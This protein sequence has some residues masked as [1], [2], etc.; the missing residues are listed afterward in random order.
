M[1]R[2]YQGQTNAQDVRNINGV[3]KGFR[4]P[5]AAL[6]LQHKAIAATAFRQRILSLIEQ[7][8]H[9]SLVDGLNHFMDIAIEHEN[10]MEELCQGAKMPLL[11]CQDF[12]DVL[13]RIM[14][15][16]PKNVRIQTYGINM[17]EQK[18]GELG[19][20]H[21]N[22]IPTICL[23]IQ[24][25]GTT[26]A[27]ASV[28]VLCLNRITSKFLTA[29]LSVHNIAE[30]S[31]SLSHSVLIAM[32]SSICMQVMSCVVICL[33][34]YNNVQDLDPKA[35]LERKLICQQG[36]KV[37]VDVL[38][39]NV[40]GVH[41]TDELNVTIL[42][43]LHSNTSA[44]YEAVVRDNFRNAM[45]HI[46]YDSEIVLRLLLEQGNFHTTT[47]LV[48]VMRDLILRG[49]PKFIDMLCLYC[50]S[51]QRQS[52]IC[53]EHEL[54][55]F[56][57]GELQ[58]EDE[59][60]KKASTLRLFAA[61]CKGHRGNQELLIM[62][63]GLVD[64]RNTLS[65]ASTSDEVRLLCL[66]VLQTIFEKHNDQAGQFCDSSFFGQYVHYKNTRG[67]LV[68]KALMDNRDGK[69][70]IINIIVPY[71]DN[72][73]YSAPMTCS[74]LVILSW[75]FAN[76]HF[77]SD[78]THVCILRLVMK[79]VQFYSNY[80]QYEDRA[81]LC[82]YAFRLMVSLRVSSF[83]SENLGASHL[84][85]LAN[86]TTLCM[87]ENSTNVPV[88]EVCIR[89]LYSMALS[90]VPQVSDAVLGGPIVK[91]DVQAFLL[92]S[93]PDDAKYL[94]SMLHEISQRI[95]MS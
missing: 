49:Q 25:H 11:R 69:Q 47:N 92:Y 66:L 61:M 20:V 2:V 81:V 5:S 89:F 67:E 75:I 26:V 72:T 43:I 83:L 27:L 59:L 40:A 41:S 50:T 77:Q 82:E 80:V 44:V 39:A 58:R 22:E 46:A 86:I 93:F 53:A 35:Q 34:H 30:I 52:E 15:T 33:Q 79:C 65:R 42:A 32:S 84:M 8:Q 88:V 74:S 56:M 95:Q 55:A 48:Q 28:A 70:N 4:E 91:A 14:Q 51:V 62:A 94:A 60:G 13:I 54:H 24:K 1:G 76:A 9:S 10:F 57:F 87:K 37:L 3:C 19:I 36:C 29:T 17:L 12:V 7:E 23:A 18:N 68:L 71:L 64:L 6:L 78:A 38:Q 73:V 45:R 63:G 16:H 31:Y 85:D 21:A 90:H